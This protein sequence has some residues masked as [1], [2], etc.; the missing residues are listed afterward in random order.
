MAPSES[1]LIRLRLARMKNLAESL[2]QACSENAEQREALL[3]FQRELQALHVALQPIRTM[4]DDHPTL[5]TVNRVKARDMMTHGSSTHGMSPKDQAELED[6]IEQDL[7][8]A[9]HQAA[10]SEE[11]LTRVEGQVQALSDAIIVI[12]EPSA[13]VD[14]AVRAVKETRDKRQETRDKRQETRGKAPQRFGPC[15]TSG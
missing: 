13:A 2:E 15:F 8:T 4:S 12:A 5:T 1:Q 7:D 10:D 9:S 3:R 6:A 14:G 11:R